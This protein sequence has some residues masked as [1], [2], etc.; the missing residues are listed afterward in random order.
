L[1]APPVLNQT[2]ALDF[3]ADTLYD[4]RRVRLLTGKFTEQAAI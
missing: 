1:A 2:W 3:M 4:G